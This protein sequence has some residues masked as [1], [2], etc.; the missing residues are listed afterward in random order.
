[1][2]NTIHVLIIMN[3][4][5]QIREFFTYNIKSINYFDWREKNDNSF[6][7]DS[8]FKWLNVDIWGFM[9]PIFG[10]QMNT[11]SSSNF[12]SLFI[13]IIINKIANSTFFN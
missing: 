9:L 1:M 8:F 12:Y 10:G 6:E 2:S 3:R 11:K 4:N 5:L 13:E 7:I